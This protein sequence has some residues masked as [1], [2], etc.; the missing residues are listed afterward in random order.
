MDHWNR[1]W[2][3]FSSATMPQIMDL[4]NNL[5]NMASNINEMLQSER[6]YFGYLLGLS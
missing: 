5:N 6:S 4:V 2:S 3:M 1:D